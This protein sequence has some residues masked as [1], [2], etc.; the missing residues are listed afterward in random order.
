MPIYLDGA[1]TQPTSDQALM[2]YVKAVNEYQY[3]PSS[4]YEGGVRAKHA[5][6]N[7]REKIARCIN[8]ESD[9][10]IFTSGGT[11]SNN[12]ILQGFFR[13]K[14]DP[15]VLI[16]SQIE[17]PSILRVAEYLDD[18]MSNLI[19]Y[20]LSVDKDGEVDVGELESTITEELHDG[21]NPKNILVSIQGLNNEI[22]ILQPIDEISR[23]C[24]AYNVFYHIDAVQL[25]PH[26]YFTL[27]DRWYC[28]AASFS[29]HKFGG[30]RGSGFLY[31]NKRLQESLSPLLLGGGQED[32]LRSGTEDVAAAISLANQVERFDSSGSFAFDS[33]AIY[34]R[35]Y[36]EGIDYERNNL[37]YS[38][39]VSITIPG[40]DANSL[41]TLLS[42]RGIYVSAGSA[43]HSYVSEPSHVLTAIGLSAEDAKST[44]RI[45]DNDKLTEEE[46]DYFLDE[47]V[48]CIKLLKE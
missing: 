43:C 19:A 35:L 27:D 31:V 47:L 28:D 3:N 37:D 18:K 2:D 5:L 38:P 23:I 16:T 12:M 24:R 39:I 26:Y 22:G 21:M 42:E 4:I 44:I 41:I 30:L 25:F 10:I 7:A 1:A 6:Q 9:E 14:T 17:H 11:E 33:Y 48:F 32:G 13:D 46:F 36:Q 15:C 40:V 20:Y 8:C 29:A 45:C 34:D